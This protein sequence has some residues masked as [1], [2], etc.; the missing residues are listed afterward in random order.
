[1]FLLAPPEIKF[2]KGGKNFEKEIK[3]SH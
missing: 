3:T 1:M 2:K